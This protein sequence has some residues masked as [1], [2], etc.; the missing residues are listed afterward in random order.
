MKN[1]I[2]FLFF[3]LFIGFKTYS[4][5]DDAKLLDLIESQR[6]QDVATYL[7]RIYP[8]G[9]NEPKIISRL[10]YA[11]YMSGDLVKAENNYLALLKI[12]S[13]KIA[14]INSLA[15][16]ANKR[17]N[18]PQMI[19]YYDKLLKLD[20]S[21][22][23][24]LKQTAFAY[25]QLDNETLSFN[26]F[27]KANKVN[28]TDAEIAYELS[29]IYMSNLLFEKALNVLTPALKQDSSN[30]L[31]QRASLR[32]NGFLKNFKEMVKIGE[33]LIKLG[34]TSN[35]TYNQLAQAYYYTNDYKNC[36]SYNQKIIDAEAETETT[37][38]FIGLSYRKLIDL[39]KS[40]EFLNRAIAKGISDNICIY[41]QELGANREAS[42]QFT[43][44]IYNYKK[45]LEFA[46]EIEKVNMVNYSIAR[47]YDAKLKQ[48]KTAVKYYQQYIKDAN[49][50]K[51]SEI[52]YIDYSKARVKEIL[53]KTD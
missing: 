49:P 9:S 15:G 8:N 18:Y 27:E 25:Q 40:N 48:P 51:K 53:G 21:N 3:T 45:A 36:L 44:S 11:Y 33:T 12:D 4:Q 34:D 35:E 6:Y 46:D 31:L 43:T 32:L 13:T 29:K 1:I 16:I 5:V 38:Y 17:G 20:S 23:F 22:F 47:I 37:F 26:F 50:K 52:P 2:L 10:A 42:N 24:I 39:K 14:T 7:E 41:Y 30:L 19:N 28:A